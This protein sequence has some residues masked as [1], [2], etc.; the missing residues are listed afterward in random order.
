[1]TLQM[2][3]V[4]I[5]YTSIKYNGKR[6]KEKKEERERERQRKYMTV[7]KMCVTLP[8][9]SFMSIGTQGGQTPQWA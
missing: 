3:A 6:K 2:Q 9:L 7:M 1:M 4:G 8:P 5:C